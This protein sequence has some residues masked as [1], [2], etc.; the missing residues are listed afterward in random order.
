MGTVKSY[1]EKIC[2]EC[3]KVFRTKKE[4]GKY[5]SE[6]CFASARMKNNSSQTTTVSRAVEDNS[7][8]N[9][10]RICK[11]CGG[12]FIPR[13][14]VQLYCSYDCSE[15]VRKEKEA[16]K[17]R[18]E[19]NKQELLKNIQRQKREEHE[20]ELIER[21]VTL[22]AYN[23]VCPI[24]GEPFITG[25]AA[26]KYCSRKCKVMAQNAQKKKYLRKKSSDKKSGMQRDYE[27]G[28]NVSKK[29]TCKNDSGDCFCRLVDKK[30]AED[31]CN[32]TC[33]FFEP[34]NDSI[35]I[36]L[37]EEQYQNIVEEIKGIKEQLEKMCK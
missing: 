20:K 24:C 23:K 36:G 6:E 14:K 22:K 17:K 5:C 13:A 31:K 29:I 19:L 3:G 27:R 1:Y 34:I 26:T 2:P 21:K 25:Q 10:K 16:E 8:R 15:E 28:K 7:W 4:S 18:I 11:Q 9:E 35:R 30:V 33:T 32:S 37:L 12:E